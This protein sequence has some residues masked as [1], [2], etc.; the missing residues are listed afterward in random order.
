[1]GTDRGVSLDREPGGALRVQ[2]SGSFGLEE[3]L[4]PFDTVRRELENDPPKRVV[5]DLSKLSSWDSGV[6]S[7]LVRVDELCTERGIATE[8]DSL[9]DGVQRL[10][11][12]AEA[13][14]ETKDARPREAPPPFVAR[15]GVATERAAE[16]G[17]E[18]VAFLG[19]LAMAVGRLFRGKAR[20]RFVDLMLLIQD[21]GAAAL[22]I[23]TL[24]S[25]LVGLIL[26][27]VGAVQLEQ[28]GAQIY[29]ANL[30]GIAMAREMGAMMAAIIMA[31]RTG[32][33]FAAQIGTMQVNQEI[34]ALHTMGLPPLDFLVLPRMLAM[35]L[36]MP[37]LCLYADFIGM[38][39]GGLVG[40]GML[41]LPPVVYY[42]Q[43]AAAVTLRDFSTGI[44]KSSVFGILIAYAGCLRGIQCGNSA[45]AVG[46]AAT[47]AV[48]TGIV[49][50][51]VTDAI[52]TVVFNIIGF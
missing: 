15:I 22:P 13:V 43:T 44:M 51:I 52:F 12:L 23:V 21:C 5:F 35:C 34:D 42:N 45:S 17:K 47:S 16:G 32:A 6:V 24:I 14:P 28:F 27:F 31:G 2:L 30:V 39:G 29:V 41:D 33:S 26:A 38:L 4:P 20:F 50:I 11:A 25:F 19:E 49:L 18:M 36:M 46:D 37:L 40:V 7:F 48:V 10:V 3:G 9:P 1:M 8:R